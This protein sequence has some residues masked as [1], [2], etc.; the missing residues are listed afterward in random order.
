[1]EVQLQIQPCFQQQ[2]VQSWDGSWNR[3]ISQADTDE[4]YVDKELLLLI[5]YFFWVCTCEGSYS[6]QILWETEELLLPAG[7]KEEATW[8]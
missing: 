4:V 3:P 5:H 2:T 8:N 6:N 1:M 7:R